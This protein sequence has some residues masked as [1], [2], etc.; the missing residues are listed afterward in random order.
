[1]LQQN[2]QFQIYQKDNEELIS[3]I[4]KAE[5]T[6]NEKI[7]KNEIAEKILLN[8][9]DSGIVILDYFNQLIQEIAAE[10][11][12]YDLIGFSIGMVIYGIFV[13]HFYRF[14]SKRDMFSLNIEKR[15]TQG[16]FKPTGKK[17]SA[18]IS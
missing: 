18:A 10:S 11:S 15:I 8:P 13:Y 4:E 7:L 2:N 14:L 3:N 1:V 12:I 16:K 5:L 17:T 9:Q 6:I